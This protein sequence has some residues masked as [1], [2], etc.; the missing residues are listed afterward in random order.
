[1]SYHERW[2][3]A[4]IERIEDL[5]PTVR[6]FEIA[7]AEGVQAWQPGAHLGVRVRCGEREEQRHYSLLDLG[8]DDGR[9]RIAVRRIE[10]GLGGSRYMWSLAV[11][12]ALEIAQPQDDFELGLDAPAYVMLAGGIGVTPLLSMAR[13]VSRRGTAVQFHYA[14]R[15]RAEAVFA[16]LLG[17]WLGDGLHLHVSNAGS[18]LDVDRLVAECR[19]DAELYVCGPIGMLDA[20]RTAWQRAGRSAARLRFES[21]GSGGHHANQPFTVSLPRYGLELAVSAHES[22]LSVLETA[23]VETLSGCRRGECG[24]CAVDILECDESLDHRDVFF[25]EA[26]KADGKRICTCVSRPTGGRIVIDTDYRGR[27]ARMGS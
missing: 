21:F 1:M 6:L 19:D 7:P 2:T 24:L 14:V 9:Y 12:A 22:I 26:Q 16:E 20:A 25:S 13:E 15:S 8:R 10:D 3:G 4:R 17:E 23:G 18:R 5:S 27:D 11:G